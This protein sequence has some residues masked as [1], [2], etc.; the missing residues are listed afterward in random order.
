MVRI[1]ID[2]DDVEITG[3]PEELGKIAKLQYMEVSDTLKIKD[4]IPH[5]GRQITN[6]VFW[7]SRRK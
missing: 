6:G 3:S 7:N 5:R 2:G 4:P 1:S